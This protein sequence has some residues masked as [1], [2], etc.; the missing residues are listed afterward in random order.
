MKTPTTILFCILLSSFIYSQADSSITVSETAT[1][2]TL[3]WIGWGK[4]RAVENIANNNLEILVP[5]GFIGSEVLD[6]DKEFE[7]KYNVKFIYQG[8][9]QSAIDNQIEYNQIIF[10]HLDK[11][12][13]DTW[14]KT[15]RKDLV[16]L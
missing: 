15:V 6:G 14:R 3:V 2:D 11:K 9:V 7:E 13:G 8:C 12:Y 5:G 4:E 1:D 10:E 16:G